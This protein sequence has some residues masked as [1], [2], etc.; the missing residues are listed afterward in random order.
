MDISFRQ[1]LMP[2]FYLLALSS[3]QRKRELAAVVI[4]LF[5]W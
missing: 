5:K 1:M 4:M 2:Q 3:A